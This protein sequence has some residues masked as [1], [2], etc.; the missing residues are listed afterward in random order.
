MPADVPSFESIANRPDQSTQRLTNWL[1]EPHAPM[2][3]VHLT[4]L[5]IRDL[6]GYILSLR[7][8]K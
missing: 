5:E 3:N 4:R 7:K 1:I 2:P 8:E 6:S